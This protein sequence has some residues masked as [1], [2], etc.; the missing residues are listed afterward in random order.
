MFQHDLH[1]SDGDPGYE[2]PDGP[3][4]YGTDVEYKVNLTDGR[5]WP[6]QPDR[7][8]KASMGFEKWQALTADDKKIWD[9]LSQ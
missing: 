2:Y 8:Y 4:D 7:P 6:N 9:P 3:H 1:Y 5:I